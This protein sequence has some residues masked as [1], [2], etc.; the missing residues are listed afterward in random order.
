MNP[1]R[2]MATSV[3]A[4]AAGPSLAAC[5]AG[6]TSA[7]PRDVA[8]TGREAQR[9]FALASPADTVRVDAQSRLATI[10]RQSIRPAE[11]FYRR[12]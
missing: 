9:V 11:S 4:C 1:Y 12:H 5:S 7:K 6:V 2:L 8:V 10:N 3:T